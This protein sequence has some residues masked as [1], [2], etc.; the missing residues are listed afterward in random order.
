MKQNIHHRLTVMALFGLLLMSCN[1]YLDVTPKGVQMLRTVRDYDLWLNNT[2]LETS[3]PSDLNLLSDQNDKPVI[4]TALTSTEDR[5]YTWQAQFIV[6]A[7]GN[8]ALWQNYYKAIYLYNTLITGIDAAT[9]GTDQERKKLKAEALLGRAF[10]YL[11]LVNLYGKAYN[12]ATASQDL[13]VPFVTS[14]DVTE[15]V[16]DRSTVQQIYDRIVGDITAAIPDLPINNNINRF[17]GS[18]SSAYG[19]LARTYL[20]MGNYAKASESAQLALNNGPNI[21]LDYTPL[22]DAKGIPHLIKR[23]DA[24]YA[25]L[26][27][28]SYLGSEIPTLDF[29]KSFDKTDLRLKLYYRLLGDFSFT[30]RGRTTFWH[31]GAIAGGY[32]NWGISVAEMRLIIAEAAARVNDLT[33]ACDEL[34]AIRKKRFPVA[35]Y[36]KYSSTDKEQVFQKVMAERNFEMAYTGTRWFDMKRLDAQGRMPVVN[37][38]NGLGEVIATLSPGSNK[39]TLQIPVQVM[40]YNSDWTQNPL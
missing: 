22:A 31:A 38:Y 37:R 21:I 9:G 13:A 19:V 18:V 25:R 23:S 7:P 29:L 27:G 30:V 1:K 17:R 35:G 16:P 5:V 39:Y 32:I 40:Y 20:Y 28:I 14:I 11:G 12:P 15:P 24:I 4:S 26:G 33:K 10:E 8:A 2:E 6:E 36:Q 3:F 34:D